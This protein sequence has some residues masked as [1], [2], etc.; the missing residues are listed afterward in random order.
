MSIFI[1]AFL[2][3]VSSSITN[4]ELIIVETDD[5]SI[6]GI[7]PFEGSSR[8][9]VIAS[10]PIIS[11][12][13]KDQPYEFLISSSGQVLLYNKQ[14]TTSFK[15]PFDVQD[16]I[17]SGPFR[18]DEMPDLIVY[19]NKNTQMLR[20]DICNG[21][22]VLQSFSDK[23]C[24]FKSSPYDNFFYIGRI[25]YSLFAFNEQSNLVI[26]NAS[27]S[28]FTSFSNMIDKPKSQS[29]ALYE[30]DSLVAKTDEKLI[31]KKKFENS[32]KSVHS[33][34]S[35]KYSLEGI[36]L[37][38]L[39]QEETN[40]LYFYPALLMIVIMAASV[41]FLLGRKYVNKKSLTVEE[42]VPKCKSPSHSRQSS[43]SDR[44]EKC[45]A[46]CNPRTEPRQ[47]S[48]M[49]FMMTP[50][51]MNIENII[52]PE[53]LMKEKFA[54]KVESLKQNS[55]RGEFERVSKIHNN[56][57]IIQ[58]TFKS[59]TSYKLEENK[60]RVTSA[61]TV[62]FSKKGEQVTSNLRTYPTG[63][64][65][66]IINSLDNGNYSKKFENIKVLG[67]GGFSEVHLA[68][69]K[70]DD[71]LYAI[72]IV[73]IEIAEKQPVTSH[74]LFSEVKAIKTLQSKY[75]VRY[76][77]C[78]VEFEIDDSIK[79]LMSESSFESS[80]SG[81]SSTMSATNGENYM[82]VLLHIQMEYC[83][84]IT[85]RDWLDRPGREIC[86]RQV[87]E[88]FYQLL[89]GIK[90]IHERGIIHRDLKPANI[91]MHEE[92]DGI[93]DEVTLKIGDFNLA[94]F[95]YMT[96]HNGSFVKIQRRTRNTGTPLYL[97]PE[98]S[99]SEYSN[100]VDIYPLGIILL[101]LCYKYSTYHELHKCLRLLSHKNELPEEIKEM[102]P[103]ESQVILLFTDKN[104]DK[105]PEAY[106]FLKSDLIQKWKDE[107]GI[108]EDNY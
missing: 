26:W 19:G 46:L 32:I 73:R 78:W 55:I 40:F 22:Y 7:D 41:G 8:W 18:I 3:V 62:N 53:D 104:P 13:Y 98:Q 10:P 71:Q 66:E 1:L 92:R 52:S 58:E 43:E 60:E 30:Q 82:P 39:L 79:P 106:E 4:S 25:D 64:F 14:Q 24:P 102:Y 65:S 9:S 56:E 44:I 49:K 57:L 101:E 94:T 91:F 37:D 99:T 6:H 81:M 107:V 28:K 15:L 88:F 97:A 76:I 2:H 63:D 11:S 108:V 54:D 51:E 77:T 100:K 35:Q 50:K 33:Y 72:K 93:R 83:S 90:H 29:L 67:R 17:S 16:I 21:E 89:K 38:Y 70:L 80:E 42:L 87:F 68:K 86:R 95:L 20:V 103:V 74:K 34:S 69:H 12:N 45:L 23:M 5:G 47:G 36:E 27:Y 31:W 84:G 48:L 61:Y 85:L 59:T 96:S 105:R 75:I